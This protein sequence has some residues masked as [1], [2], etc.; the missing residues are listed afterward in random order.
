MNVEQFPICTACG[1]QFD[2]VFGKPRTNCRI[3]E[4]PRQFVPPS[5]QSWTTLHQIKEKHENK[6]AQDPR[7]PRIWSFWTEPKRAFILQTPNGNMMW[8]MITLL[9]DAT[10]KKINSLGPLKA[11]VVSHPHFYTTYVNWS[12]AFNV[13]IHISADDKEW[14][15]QKPRI[16][17]SLSFIEGSAGT[18]KEI[19]PGVTVI[20]TGGHFPG[21]LV[22]HWESGLFIADTIV[23]V[24]VGSPPRYEFTQSYHFCY[25]LDSL[26][27]F[28]SDQK[29]QSAHTPH[30]R[31]PGQTTFVFQWSIPNG[32]PLPPDQIHQIWRAIKPFD[33]NTTYGAFTGMEV[34]DEELKKRVLDSMKIQVRG[35]GW[36]KHELL[37]E[38]VRDIVKHKLEKLGTVIERGPYDWA[39]C[40]S[41]DSH[42]PKVKAETVGHPA[43]LLTGPVED[44]QL[45]QAIDNVYNT[46]GEVLYT[47]ELSKDRFLKWRP[48][49]SLA[50]G[51][52]FGNRS[53]SH[54]LPSVQ[55]KECL[56]TESQTRKEMDIAKERSLLLLTRFIWKLGHRGMKKLPGCPSQLRFRGG[57]FDLARNH[58]AVEDLVVDAYLVDGCRGVGAGSGVFGQCE[59]YEE[60]EAQSGEDVDWND[61]GFKVREVNGHIESHYSTKTKQWTQPQFITSPYLSIHGMAPGLNYGQ[62]AYEGLKAFRSPG[63]DRIA[64]YR[65]SQNAQRMVHSAGFISIPPVPTELFL[66]C[67][68]LAVSLNAEYV[69]P[70]Q[71]GASMYIRPLLFG[72]SAQLGL[73]PPE[74]YTFCVFVLPVGVYHGVHPVAA[75]ILEEFDRAAPEGTG[76]AKVGG[77]YAPVL[78]WSEKARE[79]GFGITLHLDSKTRTVIDEFSTSGFVGVKQEG[80]Q[81]TIVVPDSKNVIKSVTSDSVCQIAKSFGWKVECRPIS[82]E[83]LPLFTEIM[84]AG[85]AAALVPIKSITMKSKNDK[86][87][88]QDGGDEPGPACVKLLT[89]LKAIQQGKLED[90]VGWLEFVEEAKDFGD[91][92]A[93]HL[94]KGQN[95]LNGSSC[96]SEDQ[97]YQGTVYKEK[98]SK[99]SVKVSH[100][101]SRAPRKAYVEEAPD[102]DIGN[103]I[104]I[105][106]AP[107]EA[108]APPPAVPPPTNVNVFD[109]LVGEDT[110]NASK[111]SLAPSNQKSM[112][113]A[114]S[115]LSSDVGR[116]ESIANEDPEYDKYG[117]SYGKDPIPSTHRKDRPKVEYFTPAPKDLHR[118]L[119]ALDERHNRQEKRSTDKKRKRVHVEELDLTAARV[120]SP[121][122]E[123]VAMS[124]V[125][126][127][128]LHTGLTGGLNRLLSKS[129][130]SPSLDYSNGDPDPPSPGKRSKPPSSQTIIVRERER[131]KPAAS[132][133]LVRVRRHRTLDESRPRKK[134]H[135]SSHRHHEDSHDHTQKPKRKAI[136]HTSHSNQD[137]QQLIV[138]KSRAE[139]FLSLVTKGEESA[140]GISVHKALKRYH[141]ERGRVAKE[142]EEKELWRGLRLRRNERGEVVVFF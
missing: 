13:P 49:G 30:P 63:D 27:F 111:V 126:A 98:P 24:P 125:P 112:D 74:E 99:R 104:A 76:S 109:F 50:R 120:P 11:I 139:H 36:A 8:D 5:G 20:K 4:D 117:F 127:P 69:P 39:W 18:R 41:R 96:I 3:C 54:A 128:S 86:F 80:E 108:P 71:S 32:I 19:L 97:K 31:P 91:E 40:V 2:A 140:R 35:E 14:L 64:I 57:V 123:D 55:A 136:E 23:T 87:F 90:W 141:R 21:S 28:L 48:A 105:I 130:Y 33:F 135:R 114:P 66:R 81:F 16:P 119:S 85:T 1:S 51:S 65:P 92:C 122:S 101:E 72:S 6:W 142:D 116:K 93:P 73:S 45:N 133:A 59:G 102:P 106:S 138:F 118:D 137:S 38:V 83:E 78:R 75:L 42:T 124:D 95:Q 47:F 58:V 26:L 17:E 68:H 60:D 79:E 37:D 22:L 56:L 53:P 132:S 67:C 12:A 110:P 115:I 9:D 61:I 134:H 94:A 82:Y 43:N 62:Q 129:I 77:N 15:C 10:I 34:R 121:E 113:Y 84:A 88:Y 7:D 25:S 131:K 44:V 29:A 52:L 46:N 107:P 70:H 103:A 89:A 100:S